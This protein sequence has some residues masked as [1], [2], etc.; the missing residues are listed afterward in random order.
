[1]E[2]RYEFEKKVF[3]AKMNCSEM[4]NISYNLFVA[5]CCWFLMMLQELKSN[6][7]VPA[8][9]CFAHDGSGGCVNSILQSFLNS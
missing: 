1:M 6:L 8:P 9:R 5:H 7:L 4:Q 2:T 3:F